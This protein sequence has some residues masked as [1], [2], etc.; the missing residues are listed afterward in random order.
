[1]SSADTTPPPG[2]P[3]ASAYVSDILDALGVRDRVLTVPV[4]P[5]RTEWRAIGRAFPMQVSAAGLDDAGRRNAGL[6]CAI[7]AIPAGAI[8]LID[9]GAVDCAPFGSITARRAIA[10]GAAGV[11]STGAI[12]DTEALRQYPM[13]VFAAKRTPVR[14]MGRADVVLYDTPMFVAG[15]QVTPG[16][17]IVADGDGVVVVP[18]DCEAEVLRRVAQLHEREAQLMAALA[19]GYSLTELFATPATGGPAPPNDL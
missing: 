14:A 1:M 18:R 4:T 2:S 17:L 12:R 9:A 3:L 10:R 8:A 6:V 16:E 11:I 15:V 19:G 7:D 5:L 13:P